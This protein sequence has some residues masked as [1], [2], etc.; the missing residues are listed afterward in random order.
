M[1]ILM[2]G[3]TRYFGK[4]TID[5][6][7]KEGHEVTIATRGNAKDTY[8]ERV[9]RV[10]LDRANGESVKAAIGGQHYDVIID[11][12]AYGSNDIP[13]VLDHVTCDRYIQMS[14]TSVYVQ[15]HKD[16]KEEEYMPENWPL[17]WCSRNDYDYGE[18][19]RQA[20]AALVQVYGATQSVMVRY[21]FVVGEDDYS[22][23]TLFYVQHVMEEKPMYIDNVDEQMGFIRSDEAGD[24]IAYL[25]DKDFT[26]PVNGAAYGTASVREILDYVE[27]KTGKKA[28]LSEDGEPA[29][30]NG[31][32]AYSINV[33]KAEALGYR[34]STLKDWLYDLLDACIREAK[35]EITK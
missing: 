4:Y 26:G 17:K 12:I 1:R 13:P 34:F 23:R 7:L 35:G 33:Q 10:K 30:Y 25:A 28:I 19:K 8:G 14:T 31:E 29:P 6:L 11:K 32:C 5:A 20:E 15:K 3:G 2:I 16:T 18:T 27:E 21:P 9:Q 24:F 22:K